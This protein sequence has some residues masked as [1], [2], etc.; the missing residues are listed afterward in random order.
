M[1]EGLSATESD[2][3][4]HEP[5][6]VTCPWHLRGPWHLWSTSGPHNHLRLVDG[7]MEHPHPFPI[8]FCYHDV[9]PICQIGGPFEILE[10]PRDFENNV[11]LA[12]PLSL[13]SL[14]MKNFVITLSYK[15]LEQVRT[16]AH[17]STFI[18]VWTVMILAKFNF[19]LLKLFSL[20]LQG[21]NLI[22]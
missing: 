13:K 7:V 17:D 6:D 21:F 8:G 4:V 2:A 3:I 20:I 9:N 19:F 10:M 12:L 1:F 15:I 18:K 5:W 14:L 22:L 16:R 11:T